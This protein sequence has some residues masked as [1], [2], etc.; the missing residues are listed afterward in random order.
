MNTFLY[1]RI[2]SSQLP[3]LVNLLSCANK[4]NTGI[5]NCVPLLKLIPFLIEPINPVNSVIVISLMVDCT[6]IFLPDKVLQK[7]NTL[8]GISPLTDKLNVIELA[9]DRLIML[10]F[11]DMDL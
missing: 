9:T 2:E 4:V 6:V 10:L 3:L 5:V 8:D 7:S 1:F 11:N